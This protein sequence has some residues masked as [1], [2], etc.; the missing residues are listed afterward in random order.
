MN[1]KPI[2]YSLVADGL[3]FATHGDR[4]RYLGKSRVEKTQWLKENEGRFLRLADVQQKSP[5]LGC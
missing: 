1:R 4:C 3:L 2:D 5:N